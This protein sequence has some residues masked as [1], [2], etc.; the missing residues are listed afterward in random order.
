MRFGALLLSVGLIAAACGG[1]DGDGAA[2][3]STANA[4]TGATAAPTTAAPQTGGQL[5]FASFSEP[6]SLDPLVS[7]GSGTTGATEM[8][9]VYD[10]LMRYN[11]IDG[12]YEPRTAESVT[13]TPDFLEWTVKIKPNIKFSDGTPYDAEA[14]RF[15]LNRHRVGAGIPVTECA[16]YFAC[17]RNGTSSGVYMAL[18]K[19]IVVTDPLTLKITMNEA[20]SALGYALSDEPSMIPSKA[21][22]Q[23]ACTDPTKNINTCSDFGL[24]PVGAGPFVVESFKAKEA[25]VMNRNP[26]YWD[27]PVYLDSFKIISINDQ[28]GDKTYDAFKGGT[29]QM[30]YLRTPATVVASKDDKAAGFSETS[31]GGGL[32]LMN[33]GVPVTCAKEQPAPLC[34]GKPDG[35]TPSNPPTKNVKVRQAVAA[36]IDPKV[37]DQR[38]NAGKGSPGS[39]LFQSDFRWDP[40]V[41][42]PT[43]D[44]AKAKQLV[45]EVK[46]ETGWDG[47][48]RMLYSNGQFA[49]DVALA[50]EAMLRAAGM[51]PIVDTSKDT[52]AQVV[53]VSTTK[54]YELSGW[55]TNI[56]NDDGA[57]AAL[58]QNL[59]STSTSNRVG[60]SNPKVDQALKDARAAKDD[61]A[62]KAAFK[63]I[64]EE[65]N[66]DVPM[67]AWSK[68]EA[69]VIRTPKVN[70]IIQ[71]HS[72]VFFMHDA[73]LAK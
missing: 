73:W 51:D 32:I 58:G 44:L 26:T 2:P 9:A 17:P 43:Y 21:A 70:G 64:A 57:V 38:A 60:Y 37:I 42:G 49:I 63:V 12:K 18:I 19:D 30:A 62:K 59:A 41:P 35:P 14:V 4:G 46:A 47:K 54:D 45:S 23:K 28:G 33:M 52:T 55:G 71:N 67:Y 5:V 16:T 31:H 68:I 8:A 15:G 72:G 40:G 34:T 29:A 7:T 22:L 13:S 11:P 25:I 36:A 48:I 10:T 66:K 50:T 69:R 53:Q 3:G 61:A 27:G 39:Q 24:K 56:T 20:W 6:A 65:L 1:D